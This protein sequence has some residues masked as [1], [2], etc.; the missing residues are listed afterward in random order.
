MAE[1]NEQR[2]KDLEAA[3]ETLIVQVESLKRL[4][5]AHLSNTHGQADRLP[6]K[7]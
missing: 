4:L 2:I 1:T 3:V 7:Y 5:S 6:V